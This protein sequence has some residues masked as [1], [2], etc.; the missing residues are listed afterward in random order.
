[1][2]KS[3]KFLILIVLVAILYWPK[4]SS[5]GGKKVNADDVIFGPDSLAI[6][7]AMLIMDSEQSVTPP[8]VESECKCNKATG[9]ISLDGG[10][11]MSECKC[12]IGGKPCGCINC[13]K[14][15]GDESPTV[16]SI[17][18][19][20]DAILKDYYVLLVTSNNCVYCR[21]WVAN[22]E[23]EFKFAGLDVKHLNS[24]NNPSFVNQ[25]DIGGLP[26]FL[27]CTND[28]R[29]HSKD[30]NKFFKHEGSDFTL[31]D[32]KKMILEIDAMIH[33][34]RKEGIYYISNNS[35]DVTLNNKSWASKKEYL[36]HLRSDNHSKV[37]DWPLEKLSSYEL[38]VLHDDDHADKLGELHGF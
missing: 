37:H 35:P 10:T 21:Q 38:K 19:D 24:D 25:F 15:V 11:S 12:A 22:H 4:D 31:A 29:F 16:S 9:L 33:P 27:I 36:L 1:M 14:K 32:A 7:G 34:S 18:V 23:Q 8:V 30:N 13:K 2:S 5:I 17:A 28:K 6:A 26:T 3:K 20:T